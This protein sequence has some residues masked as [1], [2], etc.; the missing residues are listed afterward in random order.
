MKTLSGFILLNLLLITTSIKAQ[1]FVVKK[2]GEILK[3]SKIIVRDKVLI[4][5][6]ENSTKVLKIEK[7]L[8]SGYYQDFDN[9][10]YENKD[11]FKEEVVSGKIKIYRDELFSTNSNP[12]MEF[13]HMPV[14]YTKWYM[15]K[16]GLLFK[17]F[18]QVHG[19]G[20]SWAVNLNEE[21]IRDLLDESLS[22]KIFDQ[23]KKKHK[24]ENLLGIVQ[25]YNAKAASKK[26]QAFE[27]YKDSNN[28]STVVVF[29]DFGKEIK[30]DLE[31]TVNDQT[32]YLERNSKL[33]IGIPNHLESILCISNS[34]NDACAVIIASK[35]YPKHYQLKLNKKKQG[36]ITKVNGN[37]SYHKT[38][39]DYYEKRAKK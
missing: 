2:S 5:K 16:D 3:C 37:S 11:G 23:S 1:S 12:G 38:R 4:L 17:A 31:F 32:Y 19:Y 24:L 25:T 35:N 34:G 7:D 22:K 29:R 26:K 21:K 27:N 13:R 6:D 20:T 10:Y 18:H 15:E 30:E 39:F 9:A 36:T 33:E 14:Q 28:L 8:L